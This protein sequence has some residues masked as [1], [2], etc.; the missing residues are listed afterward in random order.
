VALFQK[1][2]SR[3]APDIATQVLSEYDVTAYG[4]AKGF[5][6]TDVRSN[7]DE[8]FGPRTERYKA[9][10]DAN[11]RSRPETGGL[12]SSLRKLPPIT[13]PKPSPTPTEAK[14]ADVIPPAKTDLNIASFLNQ[15]LQYLR[16]SDVESLDPNQLIGEMYAL[17]QNQVEPVYAQKYI[18]E[19]STPV[20]ISLQDILNEN[21]A[22]YNATQRLV[23]YNPEALAS[24]NAQKYAANQKILGEETR[25]NIIERR[26]VA[27][28]NRNLL[29]QAKL[30]NLQILERQADKQ[31][32]ALSKT[33]ATTQAALN[34]IASKYAQ[35]KL[36]NRTLAVYENMYNYRY[37]P[38][39]RL[40]N[41]QMAQFNIP[42]VGST[43]QTK[44]AKG[45]KSVKK[46]NLN[47]SVVK[48]LKNI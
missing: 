4:K 3:I 34:S 19:L 35:N 29:N 6:K 25:L 38:N 1:E 42:T 15:A 28:E 31:A 47:S 14:K 24:L 32:M 18:P 20:D 45:G 36:D 10:L 41:M 12:P 30:Q 21:Q 33:K 43:T 9:L 46:L 22:A 5:P 8:I 16:P 2:F 39:F 44:T 17:S 48:A 37:D 40:Q 27:D 13:L 11:F 26:R 7:I 23:G